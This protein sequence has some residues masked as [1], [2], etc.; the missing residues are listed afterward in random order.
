MEDYLIDTSEECEVFQIEPEIVIALNAGEDEIKIDVNLSKPKK[1]QIESEENQPLVL[2][3]PP[4]LPC[5]LGK[6]Y[7]VVE[8]GE[9]L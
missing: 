6:P 1:P 4:T 7:K 5:T 2:V 3:Q 9:R 8:V